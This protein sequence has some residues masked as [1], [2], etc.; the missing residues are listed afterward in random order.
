MF[1][2]QLA[3]HV[4]ARRLLL[5]WPLPVAGAWMLYMPT[6]DRNKTALERAFELA[7]SG[8]ADRIVDIRSQL[9]SE[10]YDARQLDGPSLC[11]QLR[12]IIRKRTSSSL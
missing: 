4:W 2:C 5:R 10:G 11:R 3:L 12:E 6:M 7:A 1:F 8:P 9:Q